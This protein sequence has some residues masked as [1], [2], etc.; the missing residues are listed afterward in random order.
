MDRNE[1][2][3]RAV[4]GTGDSGLPSSPVARSTT[5]G[6]EPSERRALAIMRFVNEQADEIA[7]LQ[8]ALDDVTERCR[9][10]QI[11]LAGADYIFSAAGLSAYVDDVRAA[12]K[13]QQLKS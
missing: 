9:D 5:L 10:A 7:A 12:W 11:K 4:I 13:S 1:P 2:S 8:R 6:M 3:Q